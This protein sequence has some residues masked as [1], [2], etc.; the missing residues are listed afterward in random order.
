M[1]KHYLSKTIWGGENEPLETLYTRIE[2]LYSQGLRDFIK[3]YIDTD[4]DINKIKQIL[5]IE[6]INDESK[7]SN[8][9]CK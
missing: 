3:I 6:G 1:T 2:N 7:L 5:N 8:F 4:K 9:L